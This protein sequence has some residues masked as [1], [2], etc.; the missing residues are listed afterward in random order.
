M[1]TVKSLAYYR[2][3]VDEAAGDSLFASAWLDRKQG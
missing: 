1:A 2:T 3:S